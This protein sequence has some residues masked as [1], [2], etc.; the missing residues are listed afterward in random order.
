MGVE[1]YLHIPEIEAWVELGKGPWYEV[2]WSVEGREDL[3]LRLTGIGLGFKLSLCDL[4]GDHEALL[5]ADNE[6]D[7]EESSFPPYFGRVALSR[8]VESSKDIAKRA[9]E[10]AH[11]MWVC[12]QGSGISE[13]C[14]IDD[15]KR[16][17]NTI[18]SIIQ[19]EDGNEDFVSAIL[20]IGYGKENIW[21]RYK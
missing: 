9:R 7:W 19:D 1:Y 14:S 11:E 5:V 16:L 2:D 8:F 15:L 6:M 12:A 13:N 17:R 10:E 3:P 4:L 21:V 20:D 18:D